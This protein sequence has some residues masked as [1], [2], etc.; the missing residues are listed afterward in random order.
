MDKETCIGII[1]DWDDTDLIKL[2]DVD[3]NKYELNYPR[4]Q[5][6]N[7]DC[8]EVNYCQS[9]DRFVYDPF[10]GEKINWDELKKSI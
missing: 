3:K 4:E 5:I 7:K 10:T 9:F 8:E 1:Y 2:K 6:L